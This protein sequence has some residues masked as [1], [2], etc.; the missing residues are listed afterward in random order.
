VERIEARRLKSRSRRCLMPSTGFTVDRVPGGR[1]HRRREVP[2]ERLALLLREPPPGALRKAGPEGWVAA[3]E[4]EGRGY[5]VKR[6][7]YSLLSS[8]RG[9]LLDHRL[10]GAFR[11]GFL[12][13]VR[14]VPTPRVLLLRE[15]RRLG[16][17]RAAWLVTELVPDAVGLSEYLWTEFH[18]K[19]RVRGEAA[20]RKR[21]LARR[22]GEL[23]RAVHDAGIATHDLSPQNILVSPARLRD[24]LGGPLAA[25][26]EAPPGPGR[27][28]LIADLDGVQAWRRPGPRRRERNLVQAGNLPEGHVSWADRLRALHA[29]A[30]GEA[31]LLSPEAVGRLR[32]GLLREA[33]RTL[34]RLLAGDAPPAVRRG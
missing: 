33:E 27:A 18:G 4:V 9:L 1:L 24:E 13:E 19:T 28:V 31:E 8:L 34:E 15:D 16:L 11:A 17:V 29:Y 6:R 25:G 30:G 20:R 14:G 21:V 12:L 26:A 10:R 3:V 23:I 2:P 7:R 32:E 5:L 22:T